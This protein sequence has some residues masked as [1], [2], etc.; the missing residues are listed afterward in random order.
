MF[1]NGWTHDHYVSNVFAFSP[2]GLV[3]ACALNA[4]GCMH[5]SQIAEWGNVYAKLEEVYAAT[6]GCVV[7]DSAF[8]K[9]SQQSGECVHFKLRSLD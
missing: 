9:V 4:P 7:V 5:D 3:I 8:A 6:G 2:Q 1:Y